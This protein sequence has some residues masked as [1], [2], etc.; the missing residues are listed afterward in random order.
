M[1]SHCEYVSLRQNAVLVTLIVVEG[2]ISG[3]K[4]FAMCGCLWTDSVTAI[5]SQPCET[6]Q[7][8]SFDRIEG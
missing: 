3:F 7:V 2:H 6:S 4:C 5:A 8:C 1:F